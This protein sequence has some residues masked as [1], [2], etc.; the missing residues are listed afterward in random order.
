VIEITVVSL[1]Q[2]SLLEEKIGGLAMTVAVSPFNTGIH[3]RMLWHMFLVSI[4]KIL[5][6][7]TG[8]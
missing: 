2:C 7:R 5:N 3:L 1:V 6:S 8:N 4:Q